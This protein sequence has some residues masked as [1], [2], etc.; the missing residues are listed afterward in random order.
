MPHALLAGRRPALQGIDPM[1]LL[2]AGPPPVQSSKSQDEIW[3]CAH[4]Q[5][6]LLLAA[7]DLVDAGS[8]TGGYVVYSTCRHAERGA[9]PVNDLL[10]CETK[11][12]CVL[13]PASDY[14]P[15]VA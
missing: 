15:R 5:K 8:R 7:I 9:R 13:D 6:Q 14:R 12:R 11:Q 10:D 4:L 3:R 1:L 2:A